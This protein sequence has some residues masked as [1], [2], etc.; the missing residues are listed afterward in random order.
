MKPRRQPMRRTE[1]RRSTPLRQGKPLAQKT[2]LRTN[3]RPARADS[4]PGALSPDGVAQSK[5]TR[6]GPV[7]ARSESTHIPDPIRLAVL[8]RDGYS[9]MRCG[10]YLVDGIRYGLQH[11]RPRGHGGSTL[12]HT[13]ANLVTL[14]GW[15]VDKGTCTEWVELVDRPAATA[16]GWL[17][18]HKFRDVTPEEW[19]VRR[20]DGQWAQPGDGWTEAEPHPRQVEM[21]AVA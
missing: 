2:P 1:L 5:S 8:E 13:M 14:C 15:T 4:S 11:R 10:R 7:K 19:P 20:Y 9:C 21:G 6:H 12:L 3:P 17:L 18:P 16:E